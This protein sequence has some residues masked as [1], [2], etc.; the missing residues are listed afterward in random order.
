MLRVCEQVLE[1]T[2]LRSFSLSRVAGVFGARCASSNTNNASSG[3]FCDR[4]C[5]KSRSIGHACLKIQKNFPVSLSAGGASKPDP[6]LPPPYPQLSPDE[7]PEA[8]G[9]FATMGAMGA[10]GE[11]PR[12]PHLFSSHVRIASHVARQAFPQS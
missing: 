3:Q 4:N 7:V 8:P 5:V 12:R 10:G 11:K 9:M 2:A 1:R 6:N